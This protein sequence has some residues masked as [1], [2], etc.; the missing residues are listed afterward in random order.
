MIYETEKIAPD[1]PAEWLNRA[2]N[3]LALAKQHSREIYPEDLCIRVQ[4]ATGNA[5]KAVYIYR[6]WHSPIS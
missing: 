3:N 6:T 2:K 4:T 1:N 5:I